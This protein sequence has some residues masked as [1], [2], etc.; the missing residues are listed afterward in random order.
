MKPILNGSTQH[1]GKAYSADLEKLSARNST[2]AEKI[3]YARRTN[4]HDDCRN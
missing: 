2:R 3:N 1:N 4:A